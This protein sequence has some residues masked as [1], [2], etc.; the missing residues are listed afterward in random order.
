MEDGIR[1]FCVELI[2][3]IATGSGCDLQQ[4][5]A[6]QFPTTIFMKLFGMPVERADELLAWVG[7]LMHTNADADPEGAIRGD[8]ITKIM[9]FLGELIAERQ[10]APRDDIVSHL[11]G[12]TIDGRPLTIEEL[13]EMS[14]LLYMA[15][16]DT[17]AGML[18]YTF[19]HLAGHPE[20]QQ[21][22]RDHPA[23]IPQF[24][25]ECLRRYSIVT[26]ARVVTR[27]VEFA[28]CPMKAGDRIVASTA[29][30]NRD[31]QEFDRGDE[32][33]RDREV[34][35]H[36][37]FG[38]GPHRCVGSHLARLELRIAL[39]EWHKRIPEYRL[40]DDAIVEQHVGG[41]AGVD[42]MPLVW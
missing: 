13:L 4:D 37:A 34:N 16:L 35:R 36:I 24:I 42:T 31:P 22:V 26:T 6:R 39:E 14:F 10:A 33:V 8:A 7:Q 41:V 25:E 38:A 32:F 21:L 30:A 12:S 9:G 5:F 15:G 19:W 29:S 23:A 20:D 1:A 18:S 27:D 3:K 28:G 17:G 40:A 11:T 2:D